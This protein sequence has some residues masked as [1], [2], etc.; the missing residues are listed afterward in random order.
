MNKLL[1]AEDEPA[2]AADLIGKIDWTAMGFEMCGIAVDGI[3]TYEMAVRFCPE[4]IVLDI[5]LPKM[6]GLEVLKKLR[7]N[8]CASHIIILSGYNDFMYAKQAMRLGAADYIL[9]PCSFDELMKAVTSVKNKINENLSEKQQYDAMIRCIKHDSEQIKQKHIFDVLNGDKHDSRILDEY[10]IKL[11]EARV[12][13][14]VFM[15]KSEASTFIYESIK[16]NFS[17]VFE[18]ESVLYNRYIIIIFDIRSL[19]EAQLRTIVHKIILTILKDIAADNDINSIGISNAALGI[20]NWATSFSQAKTALE[21]SAIY[22]HGSVFLYKDILPMLS[23]PWKYPYSQHKIIICGIIETDREKIAA[24]LDNLFEE[25]KKLPPY[26]DAILS[27]I[28]SLCVTLYDFSVENGLEIDSIFG[29]DLERYLALKDIADIGQYH[30]FINGL[31][32][33]ILKAYIKKISLS[34]VVKNAVAYIK[35]HYRENITLKRV[36]QSVFI[37]PSRLST[38]FKKE[39]GIGLNNYIQKIRIEKACELLKDPAIKIYEIAWMVG[40][41]EEKYFFSAFKKEKK[42]TPQNYRKTHG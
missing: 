8:G 21:A 42:T 26:R 13:T 31:I 36:A 38:V 9:K 15:C 10:G 23:T 12:C 16:K 41:N 24:G 40:F 27:V 39:T 5:G 3:E 20:D 1:I 28:F 29:N 11:R 17:D 30:S 18:I 25:I 34:L 2:F 7:E 14:A 6:N 4:L 37:S 35:E 22:G 32:D 19:T 33:E